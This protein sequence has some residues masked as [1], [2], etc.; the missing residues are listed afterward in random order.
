[1]IPEFPTPLI[2]LLPMI[3]IPLIVLVYKKRRGNP[4]LTSAF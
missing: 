2:L 1:M 4:H 3:V